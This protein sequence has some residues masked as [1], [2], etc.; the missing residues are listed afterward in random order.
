M[1]TLAAILG[2]ALLLAAPLTAQDDWGEETS[3]AGILDLSIEEL[4]QTLARVPKYGSTYVVVTTERVSG[5]IESVDSPA[6][7]DVEI[8]VYEGSPAATIAEQAGLTVK[9]FPFETA[10]IVDEMLAGN[11]DAAILWS[12][13][14]GLGVLELDFDYELSFRTTGA[15]APPPSALQ[16]VAA[17]GT[18]SVCAQEIGGTLEGY[19]VVPAEKLVPIDIRD[20]LH[21]PA[22]PRDL[23]AAWAGAPLYAEH[24]A[25]CHGPEAVAATDALAPVDL[26]VSVRRF[27]YPGFLYIV[28]NGRSQNGMPGFSGSLDQDL[29]ERIYLYV[30]ERSQGEIAASGP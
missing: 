3:C 27:S 4:A 13:L 22:P 25:N 23:D 14:A 9:S 16:V 28:L 8:A 2:V 6:L 1:R 10:K 11:V 20:F 21:L 30:R 29:V 15:P 5:E 17:T 19:G 24:C 12:P 26:L 7:K 18:E